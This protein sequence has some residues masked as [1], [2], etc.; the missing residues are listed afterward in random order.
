MW[1]QRRGSQGR[2][3][4]GHAVSTFLPSF[5]PLLGRAL[6]PREALGAPVPRSRGTR[7]QGE[8]SRRDA[9]HTC[10][11]IRHLPAHSAVK[12]P[13]QSCLILTH[14]C[15]EPESCTCLLG[16]A[17]TPGGPAATRA[18]TPLEVDKY[19][20]TRV[21]RTLILRGGLSCAELAI[22]STAVAMKIGHFDPAN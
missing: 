8:G 2:E 1:A 16:P 13:R 22:G 17:R 4:V 11:C 18:Q 6:R 12:R 15:W 3:E 14:L 10:P 5:R 7:L 21:L 19:F 9:Q 20:K